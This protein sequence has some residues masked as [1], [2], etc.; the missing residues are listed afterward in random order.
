MESDEADATHPLVSSELSTVNNVCSLMKLYLRNLPVSLIP[1]QSYTALL[2]SLESAERLTT[3]LL[4]LS[5]SW[6]EGHW[7]L[8]E[9]LIQFLRKVREDEEATHYCHYLFL[10]HRFAP[11]R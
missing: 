6:P 9:T 7:T 3:S 1:P 5:K 2:K 11:H 8:L 10:T 4:S